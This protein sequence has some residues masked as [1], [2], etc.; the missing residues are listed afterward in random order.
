MKV[1]DI[2]IFIDGIDKK[3]LRA[4]MQDARTPSDIFQ[5]SAPT[6]LNVD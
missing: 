2:G 5:F 3:I 1:N 6:F 4:L